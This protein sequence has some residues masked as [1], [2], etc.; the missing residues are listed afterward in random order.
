MKWKFLLLSSFFVLSCSQEKQ[1]KEAPKE[2][3]EKIELKKEETKT[4]LKEEKP[5][6]ALLTS[7]SFDKVKEVAFD[8]E[9]LPKGLSFKGEVISGMSW[10]DKLGL[11]Y[12]VFSKTHSKKETSLYINHFLLNEIGLKTLRSLKDYQYCN[13][14]FDEIDNAAIDLRELAFQISDL[15]GDGIGEATFGYS[16]NCE[17]NSASPYSL[18]VLENGKKFKLKGSQKV[19]GGKR[20]TGN[21]A[22]SKGMFEPNDL[23]KSNPIFLEHLKQVWLRTRHQSKDARRFGHRA[24]FDGETLTLDGKMLTLPDVFSAH[25]RCPGSLRDFAFYPYK[26]KENLLHVSAIHC[27]STLKNPLNAHLFVVMDEPSSLI[28][29]PMLTLETSSFPIFKGKGIE[30]VMNQKELCLGKPS[31]EKVPKRIQTY[32]YD[33]KDKRLKTDQGREIEGSITC[34]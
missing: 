26:E 28:S 30:I 24:H 21:M 18:F 7:P 23:V 8:E 14:R 34:P 9:H 13:Y 4:I 20:I 25:Y 11:N 17:K 27:D 2:A 3:E 31:K 1:S 15:N 33:S 10:E 6:D 16:K 5:K 19:K 29:V 22:S 32:L 12:L